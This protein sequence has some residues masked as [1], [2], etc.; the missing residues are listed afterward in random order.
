MTSCANVSRVE[1]YYEHSKSRPSI[2]A[3]I[4]VSSDDSAISVKEAL[5]LMKWLG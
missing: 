5:R 2:Y 4:H 1:T 3:R